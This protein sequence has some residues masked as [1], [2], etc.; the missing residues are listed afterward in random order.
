M[1]KI[2]RY[3]IIWDFRCFYQVLYQQS[4]VAKITKKLVNNLKIQYASFWKR[5][6]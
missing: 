2:N 4:M 5:C 6:I 1:S 3:F